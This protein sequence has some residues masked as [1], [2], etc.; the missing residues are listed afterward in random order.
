MKKKKTTETRRNSAFRNHSAI[1]FVRI[2]II[3]GLTV[4]KLKHTC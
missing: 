1:D 4:N 2:N 3:D